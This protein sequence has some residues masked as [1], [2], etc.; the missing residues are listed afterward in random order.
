MIDRSNAAVC[1]VLLA[2]AISLGCGS[3][4]FYNVKDNGGRLKVTWDDRTPVFNWNAC[5]AFGLKSCKANEL[6]VAELH[7]SPTTC[8]KKGSQTG[9]RA[10]DR[11]IVYAIQ[12]TGTVGALTSPI[13]YGEKRPDTEVRGEK[14]GTPVIAL[15]AGCGYVVEVHVLDGSMGGY[16]VDE[17]FSY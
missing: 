5:T 9:G 16:Y 10:G 11:P 6:K 7:V 14:P 2:G 4:G 13:R 15:Q 8:V 17:N 3:S 12:S 1:G